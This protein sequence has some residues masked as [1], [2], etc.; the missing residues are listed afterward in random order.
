[1]MKTTIMRRGSPRLP[2]LLAACLTLGLGCAEELTQEQRDLLGQARVN[3]FVNAPGTRLDNEQHRMPAELLV[4]TIDRAQH[5]LDACVYG[6]SNAKIIEAVIRAHYRGVNVRVVGDAKHFGYGERGYR[7]MQQHR[8]PMQVGNQFHIMHNKFF[9]VDDHIVFVGTGNITTTGFAK[10]NNNWLFIDHKGVAL[11]FKAEFDQM[12]SG[13]FSV[14]K[15]RN[16]N[17]NTYQVGDTEV[18][19]LF[20]PHEDT[21][22]RVLEEL[23][24][25][26]SSVHFQ[27]FAFT[28]DQVG[29]RFIRKH[30]E[31]AEYSRQKG[32]W[33]L[34]AIEREKKV[35]GLLDKSQV[36]GNQQY[37][38]VY[39]LSAEGVP[40]RLDANANS[41]LP[42]DY[43]AGGG[44][45]HTKTMILDEATDDARVVTGSFNWSSAATIANDEVLLV[46]KGKRI[47]QQYMQIWHDL[48]KESVGLP[49]GMCS[50]NL[51]AAKY[52]CAEGDQEGA[53]VRPGDVL[54][55][56]VHWD[57][58]NGLVDN[59]DRTGAQRDALTNDEFLELYN[60]TDQPID[61]SL[62]T[63][64][65]GYDFILGF[66]PG[67]VIQPKSHFLV[68]D[69][70]SV[71]YSDVMPQRGAEGFQNP[72]FVLNQANDPRF[73]RLNLRNSS[74]Y[75][76]LRAPRDTTMAGDVRESLLIDA[77]GDW[78]PP[79]AGGRRGD[80]VFSMERRRDGL[81]Y[82]ADGTAPG[83]WQQCKAREGGQNVSPGFRQRI[84]ATPGELNSL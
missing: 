53:R 81:T 21:M 37:H 73:P 49:Q 11:D 80:Q 34:P 79:F 16:Y 84:I 82:A 36:H 26:Q 28:K 20:S 32:E 9:V 42:G 51:H 24:A 50:S 66:P 12:F 6:F 3:F 43:Q 72:D 67:T 7:A 30:R 31:W 52:V 69:H 63:I 47:T 18:T 46:L 38:E 70:N 75:L 55:T 56:E 48:Y 22:G 4:E 44:R 10:N 68:L 62:W 64:N 33:A 54:I 19:V 77:V 35:I 40:M 17:G 76:E 71:P 14:S 15:Q 5:T 41:F 25:A 39:R 57:G 23:D 60:T 8:I 1:M 2:M 45:L 27:I 83:S 29:S 58:W 61:L 65:T 78:G 59:T 13:R 74:L